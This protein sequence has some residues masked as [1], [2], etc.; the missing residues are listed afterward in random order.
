LVVPPPQVS[1][2]DPATH[3]S[4]EPHACPQL[5]Q[6]L[7]SVVVSVHTVPH[8][9]PASQETPAS[10]M[11]VVVV[12]PPPQPTKAPITASAARTHADMRSSFI[13][14]SSR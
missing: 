14:V 2:H 4:L 11:T 12:E 6:F 1:E 7:E 9:V 3:T 10:G 5:P 13:E 8:V